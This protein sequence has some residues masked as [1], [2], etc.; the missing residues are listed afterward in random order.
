MAKTK[1]VAIYVRCSTSEQNDG[2]QRKEAEAWLKN[3]GGQAAQ[4]V[5]RQGHGHQ[6][7]QAWLEEAPAG[8]WGRRDR[9]RAGVGG[10]VI[11]L[12]SMQRQ[13]S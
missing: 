5:Q 1:G 8:D 3:N 11:D 10:R 6:R 2:L 9:H 4:V 7:R 13:G 12:A